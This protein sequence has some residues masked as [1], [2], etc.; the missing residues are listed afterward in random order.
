MRVL[1]S[2]WFHP[3][4]SGER[5]SARKEGL[6]NVRGILRLLSFKLKSGFL[7]LL[8]DK[9]RNGGTDRTGPHDLTKRA[10]RYGCRGRVQV[11][12]SAVVEL[13]DSLDSDMVVEDFR[14]KEV[15]LTGEQHAH[16]Q[17][18]HPNLVLILSPAPHQRSVTLFGHRFN[19]NFHLGL[20]RPAQRTY[21]RHQ[22]QLSVGSASLPVFAGRSAFQSWPPGGC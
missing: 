8:L 15:D 7:D 6:R 4:L 10:E 18:A 5:R 9:R 12:S 16:Y 2:D 22:V 19:R 21:N 11:G 20:R 17:R 13:A 1:A 3:E 14:G